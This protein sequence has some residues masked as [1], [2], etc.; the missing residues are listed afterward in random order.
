MHV[1]Y[2]HEFVPVINIDPGK[3]LF[4]T[5]AKTMVKLEFGAM[6]DQTLTAF[7]PL[8]LVAVNLAL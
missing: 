5:R 1:S 7:G 8:E 2:Q 6:D 4:R 3:L